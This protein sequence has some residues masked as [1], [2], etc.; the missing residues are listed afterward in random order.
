MLNFGFW[1]NKTTNPIQAQIDLCKIVGEFAQLHSAKNILDVGSGLSAPALYWNSLYKHLN[2]TCL[3]VNLLQL[4]KAKSLVKES[5]TDNNL[6][7]RERKHLSLSW[8]T[9]D[10]TN[11]ISL[12]NSTAK[13]LPFKDHSIDRV[14]ALESAQHFRPL[15]QFI[16]ESRRILN[17][18]D[19]L[20]VLV[21]PVVTTATKFEE[22]KRLGLLSFTWASEH[23]ELEFIKS[24]VNNSSFKIIDIRS[25]GANVYGPVADYYTKN[26]NRVKDMLLR[27][28]ISSSFS[29][30]PNRFL[31]KFAED[32]IYHSSLKMK[33]VSQR[34]FID[35][36]LIKAGM[37]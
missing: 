15:I 28:M 21:L 12:L 27:E 29:A 8:I 25:I 10:A 18:D 20:L 7:N 36:V 9:Q 16:Q 3:N 19:G 2:T 14:I 4:K 33:D 32:V 30:F 5:N 17:Y 35:Y 1:G 6:I 34:G 26:R 31:Y 23:Y 24:L 37:S 13:L 11:N 22:V